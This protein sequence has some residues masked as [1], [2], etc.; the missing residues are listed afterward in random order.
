MTK[1]NLYINNTFECEIPME[2]N[3]DMKLVFDQIAEAY[4][5][6]NQNRVSETE[7]VVDLAE[8]YQIMYKAA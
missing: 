3:L 2:E 4:S 7:L 6:C 5:Y 1:V 8:G